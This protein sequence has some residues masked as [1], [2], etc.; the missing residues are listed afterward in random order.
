MQEI[1]KLLFG[2]VYSAE[3]VNSG[4]NTINSKLMADIVVLTKWSIS[5]RLKMKGR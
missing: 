5:D 3:Q 4:N 2:T 1:V